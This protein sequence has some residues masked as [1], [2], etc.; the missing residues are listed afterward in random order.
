MKNF[1]KVLTVVILL[2]FIM[3][4]GCD[5]KP[6]KVRI[7][8]L[9]ITNSLPLYVA[10]EEGLFTSKGLEV[11]LTKFQTSNDLVEALVA[12]RIDVEV[13]AST[14]VL[15]AMHLRS[16]GNLK[17]FS[18]NVQTKERFPDYIL[19]AKDSPITKMGD[20]AGKRLGTFPGSTFAVTTRLI[21]KT[22]LDPKDVTIEQ[23]PPPAQVEA[24]ASGSVDA[25]YTLDPFCALAL[26]KANARILETAPAEKYV[27]DPLP[28][29]AAAVS[30]RFSERSSGEV[31]TLVRAFDEAIRLVRKDED[32][33]RRLLP[34]YTDIEP[35]IS[36]AANVVE[37]W[38]Q[39]E[40]NTVPL[41]RY[42]D[43]LYQEGDLPGKLDVAELI[44]PR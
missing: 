2:L 3:N 21:L 33:A 13:S 10:I 15:Y 11:E 41:Q 25:I 36:A 8:Y 5:T 29:G 35:N 14:S 18:A 42:A 17:I 30:T 24:L 34:K 37:F 12:G 38:T 26:Q 20:L 23:I 27:L 28:A 22:F 32:K 31:L 19:V 7:G 4:V 40:I 6:T 43:I 1:T 39:Q 16:P 9:A 44:L